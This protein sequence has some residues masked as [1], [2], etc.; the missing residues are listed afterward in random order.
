MPAHRL[1][2]GLVASLGLLIVAAYAQQ[3]SPLASAVKEL[4]TRRLAPLSTPPSF[5]WQRIQNGYAFAHAHAASIQT[6]LNTTFLL[7]LLAGEDTEPVVVGTGK[8]STDYNRRAQM[9]V[10]WIN[11]ILWARPR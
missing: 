8:L 1:K 11:D 2:V 4:R 9:T 6:T 3:T 5:D 10:D 7:S